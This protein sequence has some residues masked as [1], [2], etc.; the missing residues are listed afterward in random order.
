[1]LSLPLPHCLYSNSLFTT[2]ISLWIYTYKTRTALKVKQATSGWKILTQ[3][4]HHAISTILPKFWHW[5]KNYPPPTSDKPS[6]PILVP[7]SYLT[8]PPF[9]HD[10][11]RPKE[12]KKERK[13][14]LPHM[15]QPVTLPLDKK[16]RFIGCRPHLSHMRPHTIIIQSFPNTKC[17]PT[18]LLAAYKLLNVT[19]TMSRDNLAWPFHTL[20]LSP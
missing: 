10:H 1:M 13:K 7:S 2:Y 20:Y 19:A 12:E 5:N 4:V 14:L 6:S 3:L 15:H 17:Q 18:S 16:M 9:H 11:P 8:P